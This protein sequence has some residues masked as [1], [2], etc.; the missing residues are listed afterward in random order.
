MSKVIIHIGTHKTA[1]TTIQ[2]TFH[3]NRNILEAHGVI[4]PDLS[5]FRRDI[6]VTGHHGL[7]FDWDH[8]PKIYQLPQGSRG[9]LTQIAEEYGNSDKTV[10]LSSEEFSQVK[11]KPDA[12]FNELRKLLKAFDEIEIICVLRTQWQFIQSV[13]MEISRKISP[14]RPLSL[15]HPVIGTGIFQGLAVNYN[16]LLNKLEKAFKP[17]E[18]TL[19]DYSTCTR[20]KDGI[21]GSILQHLRLD[22]PLNSLKLVNNGTSNVSAKPLAVWAANIIYEPQ[23]PAPKLIRRAEEVLEKEYGPNIK[24]CLFTKKELNLL[25][26]HFDKQNTRL[27]KRRAKVQ[28]EFSVSSTKIED[29]MLFRDNISAAFWVQFCRS[30]VAK[31]L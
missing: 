5:S 2:D 26:N 4:Y 6:K 3:A 12:Y 17:H 27:K 28:P 19:L 24:T 13:Y 31:P 11:N 15:V 9:T 10:F 8:M 23:P 1:T 7:V 18:I 14:P 20:D 29:T 30:L 25:Q 16:E 21:L 22:I